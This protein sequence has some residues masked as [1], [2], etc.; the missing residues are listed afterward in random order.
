MK[1]D[2]NVYKTANKSTSIHTNEIFVSSNR[3]EL[4]A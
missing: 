3:P 2:L 1:V 4:S